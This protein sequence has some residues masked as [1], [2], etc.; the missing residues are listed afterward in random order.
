MSGNRWS[1]DWESRFPQAP[2]EDENFPCGRCE[3]NEGCP[4]EQGAGPAAYLIKRAGRTL[5]VCTRCMLSGDEKL[6][7]L[8]T[9]AVSPLPFIKWDVDMVIVLAEEMREEEE[10]ERNKAVLH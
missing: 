7:V 8:V 3:C 10:K 5:K 2:Q 1:A 9:R 4:C 6:K